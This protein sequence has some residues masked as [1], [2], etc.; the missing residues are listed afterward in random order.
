MRRRPRRRSWQATA[1]GLAEEQCGERA[2]LP[3]QASLDTL[4]AELFAWQG[5]PNEQ[6]DQIDTLSYA[7]RARVDGISGGWV[8][9]GANLVTRVPGFVFR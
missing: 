4:E 2:N 1:P 5:L 8:W 6:A 7:A 9:E 3:E